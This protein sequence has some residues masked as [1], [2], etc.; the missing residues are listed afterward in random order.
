MNF[1][2]RIL[3]SAVLLAVAGCATSGGREG[4]QAVSTLE[5]RSGSN[6]FGVV[7]FVERADGSVKIRADLS[8]VPPGL[9]GFHIHETGNCSAPDASSAV[10]RNGLDT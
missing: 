1:D 9:H 8:N 6:A 10:A 4:P 7:T 5:G 3:L 2:I